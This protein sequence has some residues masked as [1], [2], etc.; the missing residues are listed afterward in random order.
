MPG[1]KKFKKIQQVYQYRFWLHILIIYYCYC[2]NIKRHHLAPSCSSSSAYTVSLEQCQIGLL[3][4]F[5]PF[6]LIDILLT[7]LS[8]ILQLLCKFLYH[9]QKAVRI[10][11]KYYDFV[12]CFSHQIGPLGRLLYDLQ[13]LSKRTPCTFCRN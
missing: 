1:I 6:T 2:V 13:W 9:K 8:H 10:T 5:N 3:G 11:L 7:L 12:V 4:H